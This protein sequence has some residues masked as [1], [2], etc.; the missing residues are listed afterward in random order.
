MPQLYPYRLFISHAWSYAE[1]YN[2][3]TRMLNAAP[4]FLYRNHSVPTDRAFIGLGPY[5]LRDQLRR[6]ING[7]Q[8]VIILAGMYAHHSDWIGFEI[9]HARALGKPILGIRPWA[10]QH[11]PLR[12]SSVADEMVS[13]STS[14]IV[15]AIRRLA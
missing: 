5:Q 2:R 11:V 6:Q 1:S 15:S 10:A 8:V 14:S 12:V 3:L 9:D 7:T 4:N 13:W